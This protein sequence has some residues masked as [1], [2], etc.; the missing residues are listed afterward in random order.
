M[1]FFLYFNL[2]NTNTNNM[3]KKYFKVFTKL[4]EKYYPGLLASAITFDIL[5]VLLPT[6]ILLNQFLN[7]FD[8]STYTPSPLNSLSWPM[9]V[10]LVINILWIS[11]QAVNVMNQSSDIVYQDVKNRSYWRNRILSVIYVVFMFLMIVAVIL[12]IVYMSRLLANIMWLNLIVRFILQFGGIWII[13]SLVYKKIIPVKI[14]LKEVLISTLIINAIWYI[15]TIVFFSVISNYIRGDYELIY[16]SLAGV[17]IF[18]YWLYL[19]SYI[20]VLGIIYNYYKYLES[21]KEN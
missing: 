15:L 7:L 4:T 21:I 9:G 13:T 20:F 6:V 5:I 16:G 3:I 11:S 18:I 2:E 17:F 19:I 8:L 14:K 1:A 12:L 10:F